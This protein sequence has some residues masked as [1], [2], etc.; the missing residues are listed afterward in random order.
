[1]RI[2][3]LFLAIAVAACGGSTSNGAEDALKRQFGYLNDGQ[4]ARLT[5][6][7]EHRETTQTFHEA[8]V[9][10]AWRW[11]SEDPIAAGKC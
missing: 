9:D 11:I 2:A 8:K 7:N 6:G 5:H 3:I 4:W 10:G 1:M